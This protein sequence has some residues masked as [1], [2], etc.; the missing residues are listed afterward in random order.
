MGSPRRCSVAR[1]PCVGR[2]LCCQHSMPH[3]SFRR[4]FRHSHGLSLSWYTLKK[5]R[6]RNML[7][8]FEVGKLHESWNRSC[9]ALSGSLLG[10][11]GGGPSPVAVCFAFLEIRKT[12]SNNID[13][14]RVDKPTF[15]DGAPA[16]LVTVSCPPGRHHSKVH[17]LRDTP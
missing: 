15:R 13:S 4:S 11:F 8:P 17:V 6:F 16:I 5:K 9:A 12:Q 2:G 7:L 14:Y 10:R 3:A 1:D